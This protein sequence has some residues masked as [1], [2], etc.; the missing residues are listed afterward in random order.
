MFDG[1]DTQAIAFT[2][3]AIV[4]TFG[5]RPGDLAPILI[6][7]TLGMTIGAM[8]LGLIGDR[9]GRRPALLGGVAVFSVASLLTA[10][11][12]STAQILALRFIAGLGMGG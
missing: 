10:C 1:F 7:G 3:P 5:L 9:V 4:A 11:A 8:T 6:A 12:S 2:G